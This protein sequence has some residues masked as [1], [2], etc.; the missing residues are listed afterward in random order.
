MIFVALVVFIMIF[1][2]HPMKKS[3]CFAP[4]TPER[5]KRWFVRKKKKKQK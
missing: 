4:M 2:A 1:L 3:V 5:D